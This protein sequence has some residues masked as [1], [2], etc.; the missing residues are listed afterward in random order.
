MS[1]WSGSDRRRVN[2]FELK[3]GKFDQMLGGV[4]YSEGGE[5]LELEQTR[6]AVDAPSL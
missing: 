1:T 2:G 6:E 4:F 5:A 3:E